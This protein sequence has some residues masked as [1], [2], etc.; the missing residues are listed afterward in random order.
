VG[1]NYRFQPIFVNDVAR[2]IV[3]AIEIKKN[4]GQIYEIGGEKIISFG[5]MVKL[6]LKIVGKKRLVVEMPMTL[7]KMQSA[8]LNLLPIS[9]ILTK[10]QCLILSEKDNVVSGSYLAL[11]DLNIKPADVE[12]EMEKWL[13]RYRSGGEFAK[14]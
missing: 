12:I 9:P 4:E 3:K 5:D 11:K 7:A 1:I 6:I 10:D 14:V 8:L 2:A 13:W